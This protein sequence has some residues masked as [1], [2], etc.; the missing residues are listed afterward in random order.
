MEIQQWLSNPNRTFCEGLAI[1]KTVKKHTKNDLFFSQVADAKQGTIHF[2]IL[3]QELSRIARINGQISSEKKEPESPPIKVKPIISIKPVEANKNEKPKF[4]NDKMYN[5]NELPADL[6]KKFKE[7]QEL[8]KEISGTQAKMKAVAEGKENDNERAKLR[9]SI[10]TLE[11]KRNKNWEL[12]DTW[13]NTERGKPAP[14][15]TDSERAIELAKAIDAARKYL[16]RYFKSESPAQIAECKTRIAFL[17]ENG[18]VWA[19]SK[20]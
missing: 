1:Y 19:Q 17:K 9:K 3:Q 14:V 16:Q 4:Y 10:E 6:Q 15:K 20:K 7:N 13:W 2:N 18:I 12:I 8:T 5:V 11:K